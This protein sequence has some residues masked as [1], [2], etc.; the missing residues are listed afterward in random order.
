MH[1]DFT[2]TLGQV[3]VLVSFLGILLRIES[4]FRLLIFE[5]EL[6]IEDYCERKG[7]KVSDLP[8][9]RMRTLAFFRR[10]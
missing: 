6:L 2:V 1:F 8:T 7:K 4:F 5:H 10:G 3:V 9:R